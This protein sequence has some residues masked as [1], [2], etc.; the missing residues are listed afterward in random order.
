MKISTNA[1]RMAGKETATM[2]AQTLP[3]H[4]AVHVPWA[5]T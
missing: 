5:S 4:S 3:G 2:P 1:L